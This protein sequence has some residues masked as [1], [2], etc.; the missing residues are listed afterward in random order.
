M[1]TRP[2]LLSKTC[3]A[4]GGRGRTEAKLPI[5]SNAPAAELD[6]DDLAALVER[7]SLSLLLALVELLP[8]KVFTCTTCHAEFKLDNPAARELVGA[9][10]HG[11][12][13]VKQPLKPRRTTRPARPPAA[14]SPA[15]P[16]APAERPGDVTPQH[17]A[18]WEAE[19]LDTLFDYGVDE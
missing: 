7:Q 1:R 3:L 9:M 17:P 10:L 13:P 16:E 4:C 19:S 14:A 11:M 12:R 8:Y 18:D 2:I 15:P 6:L 5:P